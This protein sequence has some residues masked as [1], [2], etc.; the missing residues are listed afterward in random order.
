MS[1]LAQALRPAQAADLAAF[2]QRVGRLPRLGDDPAPW[3]YRGWMLPYVILAHEHH[4]AVP[5]HWGYHLRT[6]EAGRLLDE[7]IE[8]QSRSSLWSSVSH[9]PVTGGRQAACRPEG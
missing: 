6:L 9:G 7:P 4:P 2:V 8:A 5:D 1:N 3:R